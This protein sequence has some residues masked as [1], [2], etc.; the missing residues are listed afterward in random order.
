MITSKLASW[1]R[2]ASGFTQSVLALSLVCSAASAAAGKPLTA[3]AVPQAVTSG[4]VPR[5]AL[6]PAAQ[7]LKLSLS[8]P[9]RN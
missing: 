8:L 1:R 4:Q 3:Q 2:K 9:P 6:L 7:H 5:V